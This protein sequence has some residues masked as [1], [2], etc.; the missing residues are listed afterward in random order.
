MIWRR[1]LELNIN[2]ITFENKRDI[3]TDYK[4]E[5]VLDIYILKNNYQ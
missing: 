5:K 1:D 4:I 3:P 2:Y